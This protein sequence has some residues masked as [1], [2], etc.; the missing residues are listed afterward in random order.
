MNRDPATG[1]RHQPNPP[2]AA[3]AEQSDTVTSASKL[4]RNGARL[5]GP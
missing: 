3:T 4:P 1:H 5:A 2:Q